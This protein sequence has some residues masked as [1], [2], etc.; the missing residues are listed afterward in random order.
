MVVQRTAVIAAVIAAVGGITAAK[1][2]K[3]SSAPEHTNCLKR[4]IGKQLDD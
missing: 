3:H 4:H 2:R 1:L